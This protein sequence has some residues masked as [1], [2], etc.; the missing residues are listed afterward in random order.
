MKEQTELISKLSLLTAIG[1]LICWSENLPLKDNL[2]ERTLD[3]YKRNIDE[4]FS[5]LDEDLAQ[6]KHLFEKATELIEERTDFSDGKKALINPFLHVSDSRITN[7][8]SSYF[9]PYEFLPQTTI[10]Y[11]N[12]DTYKKILDNF[13]KDVSKIAKNIS[14]NGLLMLFE[15]HLSQIPYNPSGSDISLYKFSTFLSGLSTSIFI[16]LNKKYGEN[17]RQHIEGLNQDENP[18]LIIIGDVSGIQKFIYTIS[19]KGALRSLK[20]RSF[21]LE[22]FTEHVIDEIIEKLGLTRTNLLIHA[23]GN[24]TILG[25]NTED[26]KI[27]LSKIREGLREYLLKE[28][29]GD[30]YLHLEYD[31]IGLSNFQDSGKLLGGVREKIEHSKLNKWSSKL[32]SILRPS[33]PHESCLTSQCEVCFREDVKIKPKTLGSSEVLIC[34]SCYHQYMLGSELLEIASGTKPVIYKLRQAPKEDYVEIGD[35]YFCFRRNPK[36]T[37]EKESLRI[38]RLNSFDESDYANPKAVFIPIGLYREPSL[39]ELSEAAY[40]FGIQRIAVLRADVDNLGKIF[41]AKIKQNSMLR[42]I[43]LSWRLSNFFRYHLNKIVQG[44]ISEPLDIAGR[45]VSQRQRKLMIVYSGGDDLFLIGNWLD[46]VEAAYDIRRYFRLYT[47]SDSVT[48]SGGIAIN[49]EDYP[50]YQFAKDSKRLENLAK[51]G[52]KNAVALLNMRRLSWTEFEKVIDR[53]KFFSEFLNKD[54]NHLLTD[55]TKLPKTFFYRLLNLSRRFNEEGVLV[56]PKAA[57]LISR[58]KAKGIEPDKM[59]KLKE[60]IMNANPDEWKINEISSILV[61][62]LMRKGGKENA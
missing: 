20:G 27:A 21:F 31:E 7:S 41:S 36:E 10:A 1:K 43:E 30:L 6:Y 3:W 24:F 59:L 46:V 19:S 39:R 50:I 11:L 14:I 5:Y 53:V 48:I 35:S 40:E 58:I 57:Y 49:H 13:E 55:T 9:Y 28:F 42:R 29:A 51:S 17:W 47:G 15:K 56:L 45:G 32:E 8:E 18:F 60:I 12:I 44:N 4:Y 61:L 38:F 23:G 34:S 62:M 22:L 26:S 54:K 52:Q 16:Y 25:A 37:L 2:V 33:M